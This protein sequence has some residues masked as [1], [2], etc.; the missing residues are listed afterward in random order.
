MS[1]EEKGVVIPLD[2]RP[3]P[4]IRDV[5]QHE[6]VQVEHLPDLP[7]DRLV[8]QA[9]DVDPGDRPFVEQGLYRTGPSTSCSPQSSGPYPMTVIRGGGA[10]GSTTNVPGDAPGLGLRCRRLRL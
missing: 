8:A 5:L 3:L 1:H 6:P 9:V 2:L 4:H 7:Q 10:E